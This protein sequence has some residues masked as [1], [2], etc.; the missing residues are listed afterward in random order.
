MIG[1]NPP[2]E[3]ASRVGRVRT[4]LRNVLRHV[5]RRPLRRRPLHPRDGM[6]ALAG[7]PVLPTANQ[8]RQVSAL[9]RHSRLGI[10]GEPG[11]DNG[12]IFYSLRIARTRPVDLRAE[13]YQSAARHA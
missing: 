6:P 4:G 11:V 3:P 10:P 1:V 2:F 8:V 9:L 7:T 13:A 5:D 12:D